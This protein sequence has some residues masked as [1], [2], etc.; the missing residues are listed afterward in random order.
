LTEAT[1]D[2]IDGE[3]RLTAA[4]ASAQ[5]VASPRKAVYL[6]EHLLERTA[7]DDVALLVVEIHC[8]LLS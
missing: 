7:D 5:F 2:P 8:A 3:Q 1:H 4:L 6:Y